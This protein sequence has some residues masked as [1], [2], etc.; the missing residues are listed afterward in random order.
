MELGR[1][2]RGS[3]G[4][5]VVWV[6]PPQFLFW[7]HW[8]LGFHPLDGDILSP[9]PPEKGWWGWSHGCHTPLC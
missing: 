7:G 4:R 6:Q 9:K 8:E 1:E 2:G 3:P 5:E